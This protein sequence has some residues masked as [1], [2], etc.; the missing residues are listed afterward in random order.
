[1]YIQFNS[2]LIKLCSV[3]LTDWEIDLVHAKIVWLYSSVNSHVPLQNVCLTK[4]LRTYVLNIGRFFSSYKIIYRKISWKR[5]WMFMRAQLDFL[6]EKMLKLLWNCSLTGD[7]NLWI[8]GAFWT[9]KEVFFSRAL[10]KYQK[11]TV[12]V[13]N[14]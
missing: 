8:I 3:S 13:Q 10:F 2:Y 12:H 5:F 11:M 7:I 9:R 14:Y 1:M 4:L 6:Y